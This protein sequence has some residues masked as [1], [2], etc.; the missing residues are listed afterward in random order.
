MGGPGDDASIPVFTG[1]N[2]CISV[3]RSQDVRVVYVLEDNKN[4]AKMTPFGF[5]LNNNLTNKEKANFNKQSLST[6]FTISAVRVAQ[7][8]LFH[9]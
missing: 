7:F 6:L 4:I 9:L 8:T 5:L 3:K 2:K 1:T